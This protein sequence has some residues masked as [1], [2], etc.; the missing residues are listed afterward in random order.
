MLFKKLN[1]YKRIHVN[2]I[3]MTLTVRYVL[4]SQNEIKYNY[5]SKFIDKTGLQTTLP[6][7]YGLHGHPKFY[8]MIDFQ[9]NK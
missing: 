2:N 9:T 7:F 4:I 5:A 3:V 1:F 6:H 8:E